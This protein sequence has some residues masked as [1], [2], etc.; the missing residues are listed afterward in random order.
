M[1][2]L[3][4]NLPRAI[5]KGIDI[6]QIKTV[7]KSNDSRKDNKSFWDFMQ[8]DISLG[9]SSA[10]N[11]KVKEAFFTELYLLLQAGVDIKTSFSLIMEESSK[12]AIRKIFN[13]IKQDIIAGS[14]LSESLKKSGQFSE[15]EYYSVLIGEEAG[16]LPLILKQL[17][18]YFSKRIA[19]KRQVITALTYPAI[20][21]LFALLAV[22]FMLN[23][24][25]PMFAD[26]F[27]RFGGDL[28]GFTKAII[29]LSEMVQSNIWILLFST[30]IIVA[31]L[32]Y[33]RNSVWWR[34][35]SSK[36]LLRMPVIGKLVH[37]IY[38][39]RFCS[40]MH[41][42]LESRLTLLRSLSLIE[43]MIRFYPIEKSIPVI[44]AGI[45]KG[46]PLHE[47]LSAYNIYPSKMVS[48]VKVGEEVNKL[49]FFF[50]K[51]SAQ[52]SEE[53]D[54]QIKV[55]GNIIEPL[56]IIVL[57]FLVGIILIAMYLPL[58][59]LGQNI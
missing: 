7:N 17:A 56:I 55:L 50:E 58:F 48:L 23:F 46:M 35:L 30:L 47:C 39:S 5:M 20:V 9:N 13:G 14:S 8:K 21:T 51:L 32:Y 40:S 29:Q 10:V 59:E 11:D 6:R 49:E 28:P 54:Y 18:L 33:N 16:K 3:S 26:I 24:V 44:E 57:G 4:G 37:K 19:Q 45:L 38:L 25:V 43:K 36:L 27:K 52:Y 2:Y 15:Y 22:G 34:N 31:V 42:M 12:P 53:T 1:Q 41:L